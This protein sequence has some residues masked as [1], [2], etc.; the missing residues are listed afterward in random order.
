M[1]HLT[2]IFAIRLLK[3]VERTVAAEGVK[4][5]ALETVVERR[6]G[7]EESPVTMLVFVDLEERVPADHPIRVIKALADEALTRLSPEFKLDSLVT[8]HGRGYW[9]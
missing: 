3:N 1:Y 6:R 4:I 8:S 2:D 7:L 9:K 5:G